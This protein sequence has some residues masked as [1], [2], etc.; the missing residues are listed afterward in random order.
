MPRDALYRH[1]LSSGATGASERVY[2]IFLLLD[3]SAY[4][5]Y[6]RNRLPSLVLDLMEL[7]DGRG[8]AR[9]L[10]QGEWHG[11][12]AKITRL[13]PVS[14]LQLLCNFFDMYWTLR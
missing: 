1:R 8:L 5:L 13:I 4:L 10:L 14:F 7:L 3:T 6:L 2:V 12:S 9:S 11:I